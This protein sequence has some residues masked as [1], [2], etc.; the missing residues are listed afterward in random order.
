MTKG[1]PPTDVGGP[2]LSSLVPRWGLPDHSPD[3]AWIAN[4]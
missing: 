3:G 1:G 2:P 4:T